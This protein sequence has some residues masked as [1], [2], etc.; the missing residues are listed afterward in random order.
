MLVL[1]APLVS[2]G[3]HADSSSSVLI[4][5]VNQVNID[6]FGNVAITSYIGV[7]NNGTSATGDLTVNVTY[8]GILPPHVASNSSNFNVTS[9]VTG[10]SATSYFFDIGTVGAGNTTELDF[11]LTLSGMVQEISGTRTY[12][13]TTFP[14]VQVPGAT[15]Y[16]ATGFLVLPAGVTLNTNM[17]GFGYYQPLP[18]KLSFTLQFTNNTVP[19]VAFVP[20]SY[21]QPDILYQ[22]NNTVSIDQFGWVYT[23]T[24][25]AVNNTGQAATGTLPVNLTFFGLYLPYTWSQSSTSSSVTTQ[26]TTNTTSYVLSLPSIAAGG[27]GQVGLHIKT[28]GMVNEFTGGTY[29]YNM[30]NFPIVQISGAALFNAT[31]GISLPLGTTVSSDLTQFGYI[32]QSPAN[33]TYL[34]VY[35]SYSVPIPTVLLV[36][37]TASSVNFGLFQINSVQR[38]VS[39]AADG[40]VLIT[41]ALTITNFDTQ[42]MSSLNLTKAASGQ[43]SLKEG[44][45]D[46]GTISL[47]NGL[48]SLPVPIS[49]LSKQNLVLQYKLASGAAKDSSGTLTIDLGA[50]A[51]NFTN[52]V[53]SYVVI[54]ALPSGTV[55]QASTP[56]SFTNQTKTPGVVL[57]AKVPLGWNLYLATPV[58]VG[59]LIAA[60]FLFYLYRRSGLQGYEEEGI[61]ILQAKSDV[62]TSL[63]DQ[64]RLRG[65]GFSSF[66][67]YSAHRKAFEEEKSKV[68]ARLQDFKAKTLKDRAQ[69]AFFDRVAVEDARLEQVYREGK[70]TLEELLA[71][72]ISQKDFERKMEDLEQAAQPKDV[73][74]KGPKPAKQQSP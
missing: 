61:S 66:D 52:L 39:L 37:F 8:G 54:M 7:Q 33:P 51:L 1:A 28:W 17:S 47:S 60:V 45:V 32:Q 42:D 73:T 16:N 62:I 22:V 70:S 46:G 48:L 35:P 74:G 67:D 41:D 72:R 57:T 12:N 71:N 50:G 53:Q 68:A 2:I 34:Q 40:S 55:A 3:A 25:V 63:L 9:V 26:A 38:T 44:Y 23:D 19:Q 59:F 64:Y 18:P 36:N 69:K 14:Y 65:E 58:I 29:T 49:G 11:A 31:S 30:T 43:F 56:T 20:V 10:S 4:N 5:V 27:S 24:Y 13:L 21:T 6:Y 15:L